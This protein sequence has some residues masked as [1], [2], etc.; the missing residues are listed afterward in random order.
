VTPEGKVKKAIKKLLEHHDCYY[1]MPV[2]NGM[3]A[4][5]VDFVCV[6]PPHGTALFIEA[7]AANG[8]VTPRQSQVLRLVESKG[9]IVFVQY[10]EDVTALQ[11]VI[12]KA[13][14]CK[15]E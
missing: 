3:G 9:A 2:T 1:Y 13:V 7:K 11:D 4:A 14:L 5:S 12:V 15:P 8:K 10:G 6:L